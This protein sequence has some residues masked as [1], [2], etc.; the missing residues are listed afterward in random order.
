MTIRPTFEE[1]LNAINP[2]P[3]LRARIEQ[4]AA[5]CKELGIACSGSSVYPDCAYPPLRVLVLHGIVYAINCG[6][7]A[8]INIAA[9]LGMGH[10][11][12]RDD[13]IANYLERAPINLQQ[14]AAA[15]R[16]FGLKSPRRGKF[17]TAD[18][19]AT[20]RKALA[21]YGHE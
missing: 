2:E 9:I 11:S 3:A 6:E 20:W 10:G 19:E 18:K 14:C 4:A 7:C 1:L 5:Q 8:K 16:K 21:E 17:W 13:G 15:I 12:C